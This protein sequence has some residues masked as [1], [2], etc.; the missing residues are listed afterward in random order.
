MKEKT[1]ISKI[2]VAPRLLQLVYSLMRD[3][4]VPRRTKL[5]MIGGLVYLVIPFDIMPE[6]VLPAPIGY[7]DD[8]IV[9]LQALRKLVVDVD[10]QVVAEHWRGEPEE[11]DFLKSILAK[12]DDYITGLVRRLLGTDREPSPSMT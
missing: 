1:I 8:I 10:P 6:S 2:L 5:R 11:L 4:R 9:L 12:S 7:A 3:S